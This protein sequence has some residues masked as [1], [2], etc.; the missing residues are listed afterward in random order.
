MLAGFVIAL[1]TLA[2]RLVFPPSGGRMQLMTLPGPSG[3]RVLNRILDEQDIVLFGA[4]AG[5][6]LGA[7][8]PAEK[9]SLDLK[10]SQ[11]FDEMKTHGVT[12]LSPFLTSYLNQQ[13][14]DVF[15]VV[16]AEPTAR[17]AA[18]NGIIFL[19]GFGGNFAVQCWLMAKAGDHIDAVTVC[20]STDPSGY[21]WNA[22]GQAIVRETLSYLQQRG[23]ERIYLAGLSNGAIGASRLAE[24]LEADLAGLILISGAD[25]GAA[26]TDLPVL[27]LHGRNDERIPASLMERYAAAAGANASY[28]L[29]DGDHF[30]LLKLA[31]ETQAVIAAWLQ[32][33][34]TP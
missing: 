30:L 13:R 6:Y 9:N 22:K 15:D 14:P 28:H 17:A 24:S 2:V 19:H 34:E 4:Q 8:S 16:I 21:W 20:P 29:L 10:F 1:V 3:P 11:A 26:G 7:I 18:R 32:Q 27:L 33:Q 25:P 23:L 5:P 12:P 31:E